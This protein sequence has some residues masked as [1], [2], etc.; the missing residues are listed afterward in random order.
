M[1]PP[2]QQDQINLEDTREG[3]F[4]GPDEFLDAVALLRDEAGWEPA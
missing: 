4:H 2:S 1:R 3:S